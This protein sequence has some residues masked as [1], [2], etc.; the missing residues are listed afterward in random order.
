MKMTRSLLFFI[1]GGLLVGPVAFAQAAG[2][3][4]IRYEVVPAP[5][6]FLPDG[7]VV[8]MDG[9]ACVGCEVYRDEAGYPRKQGDRAALWEISDAASVDLWWTE[10]EEDRVLEFQPTGD[11]FVML[12]QRHLFRK[13]LWLGFGDE[14]LVIREP[15]GY[16]I[17][18]LSRLMPD[19][20]LLGGVMSRDDPLV[21]PGAVWDL[22]GRP[23]VLAYP[24]MNAIRP[25]DQSG[26]FVVG[27]MKPQVNSDSDSRRPFIWT[28]E[29]G[30]REIPLPD[31]FICA[32]AVSVD[33][34]GRVLIRAIEARVI[35]DQTQQTSRPYVWSAQGG[36]DALPSPEHGSAR[37]IGINESGLILLL[38]S[39]PAIEGQPD[40]GKRG[41]C[42]VS[43]EHRQPLHLPVVYADMRDRATSISDNGMI[44]VQSSRYEQSGGN[45]LKRTEVR[46]SVL[47][48]VYAAA[49]A[50]E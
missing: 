44:V 6:G 20:Y 14:R 12:T 48:P 46:G 16:S 8:E 35:D 17:G 10:D 42:V 31:D 1:V 7:E 45:F 24:G 15:A 19:G 41:L 29:A 21:R 50:G 26:G 38:W 9:V 32:D 22:T 4:P 30:V 2:G 49:G 36:W 47:R 18:P 33:A 11:N 13:R 27:V 23:Q 43:L 40:S 5:E 39:E 37:P 34:A 28:Q 25:M 3:M